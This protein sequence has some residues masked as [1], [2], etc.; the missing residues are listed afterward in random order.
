MAVPV[1]GVADGGESAGEG[2]GTEAGA[3]GGAAASWEDRMVRLS[4]KERTD[5]TA[6]SARWRAALTSATYPEICRPV[7]TKPRKVLTSIKTITAI[8]RNRIGC[9]SG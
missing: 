3:V 7:P 8:A 6:A 2:D 9:C 5:A 1:G 4:K